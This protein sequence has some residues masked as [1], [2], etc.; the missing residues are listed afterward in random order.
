[1]DPLARLRG[2]YAI[3][4]P[5]IWAP[6]LAT[7]EVRA[8]LPTGLAV[9]PAASE[10]DLR[11]TRSWQLLAADPGLLAEYNAAKLAADGPSGGGYE[12]RKSAFFDCLVN[13]WP[14]SRRC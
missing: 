2:T 8:P 12:G 10:H 14:A 9:T 5:D 13:R 3:V 6:S 4:H 1:M 11:F 7:F